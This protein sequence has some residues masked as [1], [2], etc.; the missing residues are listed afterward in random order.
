MKKIIAPKDFLFLVI[1]VAIFSVATAGYIQSTKFK[2]K[3]TKKLTS[4]I[5]K[6]QESIK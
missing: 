6:E 1:L 4:E 5:E 3:E 2:S